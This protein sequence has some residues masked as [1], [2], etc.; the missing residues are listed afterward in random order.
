MYSGQKSTMQHITAHNRQ[1][2]NQIAGSEKMSEL[3]AHE[4][5]EIYDIED[6]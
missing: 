5:Y 6:V 3:I 2:E 4:S 1:I